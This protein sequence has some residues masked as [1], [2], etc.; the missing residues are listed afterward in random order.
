MDVTNIGQLR[1]NDPQ[2]MLKQVY[3]LPELVEDLLSRDLLILLVLK[4]MN[5][6]IICRKTHSGYYL[7]NGRFSSKWRLFPN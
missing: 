3:N 2:S 6:G 5:Q 7:G 1:D 4:E